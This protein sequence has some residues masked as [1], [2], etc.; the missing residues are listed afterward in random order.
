MTFRDTAVSKKL[1]LISDNCRRWIVLKM[2]DNNNHMHQIINSEAKVSI[3]IYNLSISDALKYIL[4]P[5]RR[6]D[7]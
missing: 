1:Y 7:A 4:E 5:C 6:I 3:S 2:A